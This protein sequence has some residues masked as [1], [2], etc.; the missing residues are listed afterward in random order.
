MNNITLSMLVIR[1]KSSGR[2][3][4]RNIKCR[5]SRMD[6]KEARLMILRN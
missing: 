4:N 2:L 1:I 5:V 6:G 3:A